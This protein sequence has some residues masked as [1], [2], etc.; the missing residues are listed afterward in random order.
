[1]SAETRLNLLA[2][3]AL[4]G[5]AVLFL[6]TRRIELLGLVGLPLALRMVTSF[7]TSALITSCAMLAWFSRIPTAFFDLPV[8][9]Y[10]VYA[11]VALTAAAFGLRLLQRGQASL[12]LLAN[13]W[14][15]LFV[16][17]VVLGG[18]NGLD[19][20]GGIPPWVLT[21]TTVDYGVSWVYLRTV[22]LRLPA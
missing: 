21:T 11:G 7:R 13:K 14:L 20:I 17:V 6:Y 5:G 22:V 19:S 4:A 15:L 1:M 10:A 12:P 16:G 3:G 8:F 18:V 2:L 9:S